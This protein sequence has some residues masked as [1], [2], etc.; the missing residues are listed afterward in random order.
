MTTTITLS[1]SYPY[2]PRR[3]RAQQGMQLRGLVL[4]SACP[5]CIRSLVSFKDEAAT[6]ASVTFR[7]IPEW[8]S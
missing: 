3:Q 6:L 8:P 2:M 5:L 1:P 7:L 4:T